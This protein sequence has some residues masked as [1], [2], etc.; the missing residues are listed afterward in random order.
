MVQTRGGEDVYQVQ[1]TDIWNDGKTFTSGKPDTIVTAIIT[2]W[3][4]AADVS[5][6]WE[7]IKERVEARGF[8]PFA[9]DA[10][11]IARM[12]WNNKGIIG[13]PASGA[14]GCIDTAGFG[15]FIKFYLRPDPNATKIIHPRDTNIVPLDSFKIGTKYVKSYTFRPQWSGYHLVSISMTSSNGKCDEFAAYPVIVG[16]AAM[17]E[18]PDSIVCQKE[19]TS[20]NAK[21]DFRYFHPDPIN[22]GT[23]DL[24]L[25]SV[26]VTML[27]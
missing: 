12:I 11:T 10:A 1:C 25:F 22:F 5:E 19:G 21:T 18:V 13:N 2:K 3:D 14:R 17:L 23:W 20:L 15:R 6:V 16:F 24:K 4:T 9:L 8:D 7:N 26:A 27:V